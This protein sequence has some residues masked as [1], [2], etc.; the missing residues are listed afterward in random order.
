MLADLNNPDLNKRT[1][2]IEQSA[3]N[4]KAKVKDNTVAGYGNLIY[5]VTEK[6]NANVGVRYESFS[7]SSFY[8]DGSASNKFKE[9]KTRKLIFYLR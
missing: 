7:V 6:L 4:W 8:K 1:F 2:Y 3:Y 5:N 9:L